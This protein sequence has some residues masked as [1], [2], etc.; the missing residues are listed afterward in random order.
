M[1]LNLPIGLTYIGLR[2][3]FQV[4]ISALKIRLVRLGVLYVATD[5]QLYSSLQEYHG[6]TRLAL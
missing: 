4:T 3:Q 1:M 5:G 2:E 6:Q